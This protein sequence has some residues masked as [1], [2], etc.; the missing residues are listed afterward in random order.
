MSIPVHRDAARSPEKVLRCWVVRY[1]LPI[2]TPHLD[3]LALGGELLDAMIP[4]IGDI[5]RSIRSYGYPP[6]LV[7]ESN[8]LVSIRQLVSKHSPGLQKVSIRRE[9]YDAVIARVG[10]IK[11]VVESGG[12]G[13]RRIQT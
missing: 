10:Y 5:D 13:A 3:R 8:R 9:M 7:E 1:R 4:R 11:I 2:L 6:G 12:D